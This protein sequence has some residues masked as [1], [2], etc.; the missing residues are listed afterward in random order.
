MVRINYDKILFL[1]KLIKNLN[2]QNKLINLLYR[3]L[4]KE[5]NYVRIKIIKINLLI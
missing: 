5:I 1:F 2:I 3:I 4:H